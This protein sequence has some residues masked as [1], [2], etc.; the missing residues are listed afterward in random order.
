[1]ELQHL[2]QNTMLNQ[3][4][5]QI[6]GYKIPQTFPATLSTQKRW[7]IQSIKDEIKF[8]Y[9]NKQKPNQQLYFTHLKAAQEWN[10]TW[11]ISDHTHS[12]INSESTRKYKTI[13]NKL[14][15]LTQRKS[16]YADTN[17]N[18]RPTVVNITNITFTNDEISLLN[19]GQQYT[20]HHKH[21][22]YIQIRFGSSNCH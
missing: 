18:F 14:E 3:G 1:M 19:N 21:K 20:L 6:R 2:L 16:K 4:N 11:P 17:I 9:K 8:L 22:Q 5:P 15:N 12:I 10:S 7:Q 13:H